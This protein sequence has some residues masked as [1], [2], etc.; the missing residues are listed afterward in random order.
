MEMT[1]QMHDLA[2][3]KQI[4]SDIQERRKPYL[5]LCEDKNSEDYNFYIGV[6]NGMNLAMLIARNPN[7]H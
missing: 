1:L 5:N 4:E 3:R 7:G 2:L 6:C